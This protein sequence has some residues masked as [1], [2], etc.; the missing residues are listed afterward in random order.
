MP[1]PVTH[2]AFAHRV[3]SELKADF[4]RQIHGPVFDRALQGPDPWSTIG[5]YGGGK[6]QYACRSGVMH[7]EHTGQFLSALAREA[8]AAPSPQLFSLLAG[9]ICHYCL[10]RTTHPYIIAKGGDWDGTPATRHLRSGHVRLERA[11]DSHFIRQ[12]W[13]KR[14]WRISIPRKIMGLRAYPE[15][16]RQPLN[17]V[18]QSVYGWEN[19]FDDLNAALRDERLFYGLMQDPLGLV[20]YLLRPISG[21][22][23]NFCLYSYYRREID[24]AQLDYM[25]T[26]HT[27]W[28]H[29]F[30]STLISTASFFDLL[31]RAEA[32]ARAMLQGVYAFV[33]EAAE[34]SLTDLFENSNYSTGFPV[35]DPRNQAH[36]HYAPLSY[37]GTYWN[38]G[39]DLQLDQLK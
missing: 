22:R 32:D 12:I 23:T 37:G 5:F 31:D 29:P 39:L 14:P 7:K 18:V 11:I 24:P 30:D 1:D 4:C 21:G 33:Y 20:H 27:P 17:R 34:V 38:E 3:I 6:K 9:A 15:V 36:P 10:D 26:S 2:Y 25:N 8:K 35:D 16:L 28:Q 19:A 13:D